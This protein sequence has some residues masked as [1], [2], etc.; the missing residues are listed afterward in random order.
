MSHSVELLANYTL[1]KS[2]DDGQAGNNTGGENFFG[3]AAALNPFNQNAEQGYSEID[4]RNRFTSSVVWAPM[5]ARSGSNSVVRGL[6]NGWNFSGTVTSSTGTH[7]SGLVQSTASQCVVVAAACPAGDLGLEGSMTG[8]GINTSGSS[9]GNRIAWM[10]RDTFAL[11]SYTNVDFRISRQFA[12]KE[13]Y[14]FDLRAEAFN[15]F[16]STLI[17]GVNQNA[18]TFAAPSGNFGAAGVTCPKFQADGVTVL[19][20]NPCMVPLSTFQQ[21]TTTTGNLLGARQLQFAFRF[22]F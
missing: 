4:D 13:R 2:T 6:A 15:L 16:N 19:H 18:Y 21:A 5:L 14:V 3:N 8:A 7:Y 11:P 20:A 17:Q 12:V 9:L 22:E 10:P 1:S